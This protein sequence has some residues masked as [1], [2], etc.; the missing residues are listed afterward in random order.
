MMYKY[1]S[2]IWFKN[3]IFFYI[4]ISN[5]SNK[6]ICFLHYSYKNMSGSWHKYAV[7]NNAKKILK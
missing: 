6:Y 5:I 2:N 7:K 1:T 3:M 4:Y